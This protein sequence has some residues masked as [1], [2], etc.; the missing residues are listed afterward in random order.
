MQLRFPLLYTHDTG[1]Q[2]GTLDRRQIEYTGIPFDISSILMLW[3]DAGLIY[4]QSK[5]Q[6]N[7]LKFG[8][9]KVEIHTHHII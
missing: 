2:I 8:K 6:E 9:I 3:F 7:Q 4:H 1:S 5:K